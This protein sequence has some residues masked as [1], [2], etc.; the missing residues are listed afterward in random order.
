M[1]PTDL[2]LEFSPDPPHKREGALLPCRDPQ[3]FTL[4]HTGHRL[5]HLKAPRLLLPSLSGRAVF[6]QP[7]PEKEKKSHFG[8]SL[9]SPNRRLGAS[10]VLT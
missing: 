3:G 9:L 10:S 1:L 4:A 6:I 5:S 2:K 8:A 7:I